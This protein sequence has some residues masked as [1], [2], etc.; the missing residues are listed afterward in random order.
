M[1]DLFYLLL[2]VFIIL[3]LEECWKA[4]EELLK[5]LININA[6]K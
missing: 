1:E 5:F 2:S 6:I 3:H 4:G